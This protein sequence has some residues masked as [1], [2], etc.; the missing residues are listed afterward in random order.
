M[1][2]GILFTAQNPNVLIL[3]GWGVT[4]NMR[5]SLNQRRPEH[6]EQGTRRSPFQLYAKI[7]D[8]FYS[9]GPYQVHLDERDGGKAIV[10]RAL[11][12]DSSFVKNLLVT[13][14]GRLFKRNVTKEPVT[15]ILPEWMKENSSFKVGNEMCCSGVQTV[16]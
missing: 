10:R 11:D 16:C 12:W 4:M 8:L 6:R 15:K 1:L 9:P 2:S 13:D 7:A 14:T 5:L 3:N